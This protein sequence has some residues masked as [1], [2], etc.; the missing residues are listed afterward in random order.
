MK[1]DDRQPHLLF[2]PGPLSTSTGV[3]EAM[4]TDY[5][6]REPTFINLVSE[7]RSELLE[8]AGVSYAAGFEVIPMQGSGTFGIESVIGSVV[9]RN[10]KLLVIVNGAYG[11]RMVQIAECLGIDVD[12]LE[13]PETENPDETLIENRLA[14]DDSITHVAVVHCETTTGILN[15]LNSISE[16]VARHGKSLI[17]DA[18]SSFGG[19]AIDLGKTKI[20]FLISSSNKCL[21]GVPGFA[22]AIARRSQ[23]EESRGSAR[24]VSLDLVAQFD[25][26]EKTG[27]FRF[28][29]P[30][31]VFAAFRRALIELREEG[32]IP[33]RNRRYRENLDTLVE[34]MRELGFNCLLPA[35]LRSPVIT[36]FIEPDGFDFEA[37]YEN[38]AAKQFIIYPGKLSE[39]P[40]FRIGTIGKINSGDI[41]RLLAAIGEFTGRAATAHHEPTGLVR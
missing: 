37:L 22:F 31:H 32:G 33:A 35:E 28:T 18:M 30:T 20:D 2:T 8:I 19:I 15:P 12:L 6:S 26:L 36:T 11:R 16:L 41:S 1:T 10:G 17:V 38:L 34:G 29:P 21:E 7:I 39:T 27:Q 3:K 5:G 40:S 25:A 4:L 24:S 14:G 9:P 23:L 13:F